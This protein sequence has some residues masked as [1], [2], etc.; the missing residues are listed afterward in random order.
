LVDVRVILLVEVDMGEYLHPHIEL[1]TL[2]VYDGMYGLINKEID[3]HITKNSTSLSAFGSILKDFW[4]PMSVDVRVIL[5]A[6]GDTMGEYLHPY[7]ELETLRV[8]MHVCTL[9]VWTHQRRDGLSHYQNS[10]SL[11]ALGSILKDFWEP[12]SVDVRVILLVEDDKTIYIPCR[13]GNSWGFH[14]YVHDGYNASTK[15][16][17]L[18][19]PKFDEPF[20]ARFHFERF[21]GTDVGRC[22]GH[23]LG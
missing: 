13:V 21:L 14:V 23:T 18:T 11:S 9:M 12:M 7:I 10:T 22:E 19:L 3:F 6:E 2:R 8:Y 15:R 1:E 4:E 20:G 17:T 5:L 16:W